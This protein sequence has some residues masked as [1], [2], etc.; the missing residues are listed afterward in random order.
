MHV[1][2]RHPDGLNVPL[3][4]TMELTIDT[5]GRVT[6]IASYSADPLPEAIRQE[7]VRAIR[8]VNYPFKPMTAGGKPVESVAT[9]TLTFGDEKTSLQ[10][11]N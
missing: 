6:N 7:A 10:D 11:R 2:N 4:V 9:V 1:L 3:R 8:A 5:Q